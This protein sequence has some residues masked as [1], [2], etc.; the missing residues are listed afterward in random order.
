MFSWFFKNVWLKLAV[1]AILAAVGWYFLGRGSAS[2]SNGSTF[3]AKRGNLQ[4][5]VLEGG[6]IEALESQEIRSQIK[7]YQ[8]TKILDI[9]EEGYLVTEDDIK[10]GKKL[11]ELDSSELKQKIITE[12]LNF[13]STVS[14][15]IEAKQAYDIQINQNLSDVKESEQKSRFARSDIEKYLGNTNTEEIISILKLYDT[16]F[17][18]DFESASEELMFNLDKIM[19]PGLRQEWIR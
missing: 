8:G 6:N 12:E 10:N 18:N 15:L 3:V 9:V 13:Q 19:A 4:I 11:V 17:T 14:T 5:T 16:P 1:L 2:N 7:G